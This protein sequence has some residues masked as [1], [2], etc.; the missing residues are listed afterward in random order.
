MKINREQTV[1]LFLNKTTI[2][3]LSDVDP[4]QDILK[5]AKLYKSKLIS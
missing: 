4:R 3:C 2:N 5:S 1:F